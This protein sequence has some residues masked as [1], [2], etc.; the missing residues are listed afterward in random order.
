MFPQP[1]TSPRNGY[2]VLTNSLVID[3]AG[4]ASE[5][6]FF[7][8]EK[9]DCG[10]GDR[11]LYARQAGLLAWRPEKE[12][13]ETLEDVLDTAHNLVLEHEGVIRALA[14]SLQRGLQFSE[15]TTVAALS[16]IESLRRSLALDAAMNECDER[17]GGASPMG[18]VIAQAIVAHEVIERLS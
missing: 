3:R 1:E 2:E 11:E 10:T 14:G 13:Y 4:I 18:R 12:V 5:R 6:L 15:A 17:Q 7:G 8:I 16:R 9:D